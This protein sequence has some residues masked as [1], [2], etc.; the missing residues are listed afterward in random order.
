M[1]TLPKQ[2]QKK[3]FG[4]NLGLYG[5]INTPDD[6][7]IKY[8]SQ[9]E[10]E[11]GIGLVLYNDNKEVIDVIEYESYDSYDSADIDKYFENWSLKD[12]EWEINEFLYQM[13]ENNIHDDIIFLY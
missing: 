5:L 3:G 9:A 13:Y 7:K 6:T 11:Q 1:L 4:P 8:V 2:L 10:T 12:N